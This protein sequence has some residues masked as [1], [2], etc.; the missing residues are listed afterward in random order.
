MSDNEGDVLQTLREALREHEGTLIPDELLGITEE[1]LSADGTE[2][3]FIDVKR[4]DPDVLVYK[5]AIR[6]D[7]KAAIG[8]EIDLDGFINLARVFIRES[9]DG[10]RRVDFSLGAAADAERDNR[11]KYIDYCSRLGGYRNRPKSQGNL[12]N[13]RRRKMFL[14][15]GLFPESQLPDNIDLTKTV[16]EFFDWVRGQLEQKTKPSKFTPSFT[17]TF[18]QFLSPPKI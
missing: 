5:D 11:I 18:P 6:Y 2:C 4:N 16:I 9:D 12:Y 10:E 8:L 14:G 17:K 7:K 3:F 15:F 13:R 1:I